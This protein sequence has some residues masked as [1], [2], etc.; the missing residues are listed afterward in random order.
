MV[1]VVE[2]TMETRHPPRNNA[3]DQTKHCSY[4]KRKN[5]VIE[6][7][8]TKMRHDR[9]DQERAEMAKRM[10]MENGQ[11]A[12]VLSTT[13]M[14]L[15][16]QD[17]SL[18]STTPRFDTRSTGDWFADSGAISH[19]SDQR[20]ELDDFVPVPDGSWTV[21][22]IG[23]SSYPVKGYGNV[24]FWT[25][26]NGEKKTSILKR[27]LYV[28]GLGT[29]LLSIAAVTDLGWNVVFN[30]TRVTFT[31]PE[32][33]LIMTGRRVGSSLYLLDIYHHS[34]EDHPSSS[35][36]ALPSSI[37]PGIVTW[38]RRLAHTN[39][40][41][42]L[43]MAKD[44]IVEGLDLANT[45]TPTEPCSGCAF[46]KHQRSPF[47]GERVRAEYPGE[48]IHSDLCG[49]M[50]VATPSGSLYYVIFIDDYS[51]MRFISFLKSKSEAADR[52]KDLV[53]KI[54]GETGNLVRV[55]RT[56]NGGEWS[57]HEFAAWLNRKGIR[58]ET[59][60]P[61]YAATRWSGREGHPHGDRGHSQLST[62]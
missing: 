41:T 39:Y 27:V 11:V 26:V 16:G 7:C 8:H 1:I 29:N 23:A 6:E 48:R 9:V 14:P 47:L 44:G 60:A 52:M 37:S 61:P 53:H 28:P 10:K 51:G 13:D 57:G 2:V 50:P 59:S 19:M 21:K 45:T 31:A 32:D 3:G 30:D 54:R 15:E 22:G 56:D 46:G 34:E 5:H 43:E 12:M 18:I 4:C 62:R 35:D 36:R 20:E 24:K 55:F 42:I 49:P 25:M 33:G 17:Y 38:H 40:P 58:H